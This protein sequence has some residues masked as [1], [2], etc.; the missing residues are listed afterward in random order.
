[1]STYHYI[2]PVTAVTNTQNTTQI[3][4]PNQ[5]VSVSVGDGWLLRLKAIGLLRPIPP[6]T[7]N[8][9]WT[10]NGQHTLNSEA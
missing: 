2:G 7:L 8:G 1:M 4:L 10:L 9:S 6:L 3:L 5:R